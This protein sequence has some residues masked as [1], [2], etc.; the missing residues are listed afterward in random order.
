LFGWFIISKLR[1]ADSPS[2]QQQLP[3]I[4]PLYGGGGSVSSRWLIIDK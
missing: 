2:T 3:M 4:K 1:A